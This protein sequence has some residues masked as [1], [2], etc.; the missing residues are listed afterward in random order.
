MPIVLS[1]NS[2][3]DGYKK[4]R[5]L[6]EQAVEFF[7]SVDGTDTYVGVS[8]QQFAG[9]LDEVNFLLHLQKRKV[10]LLQFKRAVYLQEV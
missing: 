3:I 7:A 10:K 9:K 6:V 2:I 5:R 4:I 1:K 8:T